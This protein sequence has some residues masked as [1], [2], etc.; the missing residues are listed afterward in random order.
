M[1]GLSGSMHVYPVQE[2]L[3]FM[4][5]HECTRLNWRLTISCLNYSP[6][7]ACLDLVSLSQRFT[8]V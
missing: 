1:S 2:Y 4:N 8:Q 7:I 6:V 5:F 3:Q